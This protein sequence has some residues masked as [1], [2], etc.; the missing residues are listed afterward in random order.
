MPG[1]LAV[2]A[3][4]VEQPSPQRQV[5][6]LGSEGGKEEA[7]S[8]ENRKSSLSSGG[9]DYSDDEYYSDDFESEDESET[10]QYK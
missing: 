5:R 3:I 8:I 4:G 10:T 1:S 2:V 9:E 7:P 6:S